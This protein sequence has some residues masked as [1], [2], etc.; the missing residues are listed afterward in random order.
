MK[1]DKNNAV[2]ASR[3]LL[4]FVGMLIISGSCKKDFLDQKTLSVL[5]ESAIFSDSTYALQFVN[6]RYVN[7]TYSWEPNRFS[8]VGGLESACDEAEPAPSVTDYHSLISSGAANPSNT[9][10]VLYNTT[11]AQVRAV[12]IFLKN[13]N[14]VPVT[15]ATKKV[16]EGQVRFMRAWYLAAMIKHYGGIQLVGNTVFEEQDEINL[17][18]ST[19]EE[20]VNYVVSE[21]D[22]VA[23]L[24]P[25]SYV[26]AID[27]GRATKGAALALKARVLLYAASPLTNDNRTDDPGHLVSYGNADPNRWKKAADAAQAVIDMNYYSLYRASAPAFYQNFLVGLTAP[28]LEHI[29]A[30]MPPTTT[31]NN[32]YRETIMNPPSRG[33]RYT[34][35]ISCFPLQEMVDAFG[36]A[37]GLPISDPASGYPGIGDNMYLNRD[38]RLAQSVSYNGALRAFSG[39]TGDQPVRTYTGALPAGSQGNPNLSSAQLDGIYK[40]NATRTGYYCYKMLSNNVINGGAELNRPRVLIRYAEVLLNAAEAVNETSGPT[41]QVYTWLRDIR[42]RAGI[43]AGTGAT[44]G[45]KNGLLKD[46]MREVIRNERRVEL[47]YE[48]HRFWDVRRWKIAPQTENKEMHG[49]EITRAENGVFS[50]RLIVVSK[51]VFRENM[52]FWPIPQSEITKSPALKQNPGY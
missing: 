37:N 28:N 19:Y 3:M 14:I 6:N 10:K 38:P 24:L 36:M 35:T 40:S 51:H 27:Y 22:A 34:A 33:T 9:H 13:L 16:W 15:A 25:V 45:I 39:I 20:S 32:M 17:P 7:A 18:R 44:F 50:Y 11:Y 29:F 41:A 5:G 48:E 43:T 8:A 49:L 12:N 47:A 52:Y 4:A 23:S 21:C 42:S 1:I 46:E 30:F 31:P 2:R 26:N